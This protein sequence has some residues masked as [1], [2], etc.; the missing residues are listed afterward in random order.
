MVLNFR[1]WN[2]IFR[3]CLV[4]KIQNKYCSIFVCIWQILFN[5]GLTRL[6]R[7]ISQIK[8]KLSSSRLGVQTLTSDKSACS[9]ARMVM[10]E[11]TEGLYWFRVKMPYVQWEGWSLH[12]L[13]SES[14]C[15]RGVQ[16]GCEREGWVPGLGLGGEWWCAQSPE[17]SNS[18]RVC[19]EVFVGWN[20]C[21]R[22]VL[23]SSHVPYG[24]P[25][26]S[27]YSHKGR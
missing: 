22:V 3:L 2:N 7:F 21:V 27:F 13:A 6:K 17:A 12:F 8:D 25:C 16:G 5:Y 15:S 19:V 4:K 11:N 18:V 23:V 1:F 14:A 9:L 10:Q 20:V 26:L 24:V